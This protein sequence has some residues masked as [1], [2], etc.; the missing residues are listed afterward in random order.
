M[1]GSCGC[2]PESV[3]EVHEHSLKG[4]E[5]G[6]VIEI[7]VLENILQS[8]DR[9]ARANQAVFDSKGILAF[10]LMSSPG[11]G[12]TR[13]LELTADRLGAANMAVIEGDM[14]TEN[15]AERL[16][17]KGVQACQ[18]T[19]GMACHLSAAMV[20]HAIGALDLAQPDYLFI[21]NVG[22]LICPANYALGQH[23]NVVL[24]AVTEGDDKPQKYPV[25]FHAADLVLIT[26]SDLLPVLDDF[27]VERARANIRQI[28]PDAEII[29]VSARSGEGIPEWLD[30]VRNCQT[31]RVKDASDD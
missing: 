14:E 24:L 31:E 5:Q 23:T 15:D 11:A 20:E 16:R 19:T 25:I 29:V 17:Y 12:K 4:A 30:W 13:L 28:Q 6:A 3:E 21:E 9:C 8:N 26:K 18:I 2:I 10:N 1:C 27:D 7:S 22:N